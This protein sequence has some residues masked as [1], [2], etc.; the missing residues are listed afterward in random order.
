MAYWDEGTECT[1]G[2][3]ADDAKLEGV[4]DVPQG[5]AAI[6]RDLDK[7]QSWADRNF[8]GINKG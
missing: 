5:H 3:F 7:L 1:F 2:K 8:L 6:H 4:T